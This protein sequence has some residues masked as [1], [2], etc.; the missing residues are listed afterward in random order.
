MFNRG[1]FKTPKSDQ[2][3]KSELYKAAVSSAQ[4][5]LGLEEFQV[6]RENAKKACEEMIRE[7]IHF[8][9]PDPMQKILKITQLQAKIRTLQALYED[10]E[11]DAMQKG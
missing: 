3:S 5:C 6:Y 4:K 10:V 8:E 2:P 1:V 11:F 7:L 9:C